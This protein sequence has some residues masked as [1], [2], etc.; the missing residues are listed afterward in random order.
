MDTQPQQVRVLC[1][2]VGHMTYEQSSMSIVQLHLFLSENSTV[3]A[4]ETSSPL[5][6]SQ[7]NTSP[8]CM[9]MPHLPI[10]ASTKFADSSGLKGPESPSSPMQTLPTVTDTQP[11]IQP[12]SNNSEP[13]VESPVHAGTHS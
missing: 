7:Q 1:F 5:G 2:S 10:T 9:A 8:V 12:A 13:Q 6:V 4:K 11:E 3:P